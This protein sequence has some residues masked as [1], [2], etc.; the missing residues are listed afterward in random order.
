MPLGTF[1]HEVDV[2]PPVMLT[3]DQDQSEQLPSPQRMYISIALER[4]DPLTFDKVKSVIGTP[5]VGVPL[6]EPFS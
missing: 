4:T 3:E 5:V 2:F 1:V 6:G